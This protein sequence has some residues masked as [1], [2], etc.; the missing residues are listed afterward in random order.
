MPGRPMTG[1]TGPVT[2]PG[3]MAGTA[4]QG[5]NLVRAA[6]EL[7]QKA[8]P[9]LPMGSDEHAAVLKSVQDLSKHVGQASGAGDPAAMIQQLA[10]LARAR[11][12]QPVPPAM[13]GGAPGGAPAM[14]P[15]AGGGAPPGAPPPPG[16]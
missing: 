12:A 1:G 7:L 6:L 14:P 16:A 4:A 13:G 10:L 8:L 5:T 11:G 3:A 2:V 15:G 9:T